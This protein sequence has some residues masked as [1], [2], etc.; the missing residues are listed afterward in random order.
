MSVKF[1]RLTPPSALAIYSMIVLVGLKGVKLKALV[2]AVPALLSIVVAALTDTWP[3]G[4]LVLS[5][6]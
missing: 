4:V 3:T 1:V 5:P 2:C 6:P